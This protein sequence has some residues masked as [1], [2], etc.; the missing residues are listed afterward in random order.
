M[1]ES[2]KNWQSEFLSVFTI[3]FFS[4]FN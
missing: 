1:V 2:F 4:I 3:V